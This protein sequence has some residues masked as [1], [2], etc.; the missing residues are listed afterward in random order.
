MAAPAPSA[1]PGD[2]P[3][4]RWSLGRAAAVVVGLALAM[5]WI[6]IFSGGPRRQNPDHLSDRAWVARAEATCRRAVAE[7][8]RLPRA[9]QTRRPQERADV[10]DRATTRLEAMVDRLG[11][12]LPDK[13]DDA[14]LVRAW[15]GDWRTYLGNRR[16]YTRRLRED[17]R[18]RFLLDEKF[19]DPIDTV[20]STFAEVN[21]MAAC[22]PPGDVG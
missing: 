12:P 14:R 7:V 1:A 2:P 10:V 4:R 17:P 13:G 20:I 15:L 9:E 18:A 6:W 8:G 22:A 21:D 5:F 3:A 19:S 16:D 11:R